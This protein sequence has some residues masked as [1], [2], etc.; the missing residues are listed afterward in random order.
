VCFAPYYLHYASIVLLGVA[1]TAVGAVAVFLTAPSLQ[2]MR[3]GLTSLGAEASAATELVAA[4]T[5]KVATREPQ[6]LLDRTQ[7]RA[8]ARVFTG[9]GRPT[10]VLSFG[11][12]PLSAQRPAAFRAVVAHELA[13]IDNGDARKTEAAVAAWWGLVVA[14]LIPYA[15][16]VAAAITSTFSTGTVVLRDA[17]LLGAAPWGDVLR[18]VAITVLAVLIRNS[19]LRA[20]EFAADRHAADQFGADAD[21][22]MLFGAAPGQEADRWTRLLSV[23][24]P[25][26]VRL[27]RLADPFLGMAVSPWETFT[28]GLLAHLPAAAVSIPLSYLSHG[29]FDATRIVPLISAGTAAVLGLGLWALVW[30]AARAGA[31]TLP[32]RLVVGA[33][34]GL[35]ATVSWILSPGSGGGEPLIQLVTS[36][37][38][39]VAAAIQVTGWTAV[40]LL[41]GALAH[42]WTARTQVMSAR[43]RYQVLAAGGVAAA[44]AA[45]AL[46]LLVDPFA[47][48]ARALWD[49]PF[50]LGEFAAAGTVI[51]VLNGYFWGFVVL[52]MLAV[53]VGRLRLR[54]A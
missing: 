48:I 16:V 3:R 51:A 45:V 9:P 36:P 29:R 5:A 32:A 39:I 43:T 37:L 19:I 35:G 31:C 47:R 10:L 21:L 42:S 34:L 1:C 24:P 20:R 11:M 15:V 12:L 7:A 54:T 18:M 41:I 17:P 25:A 22:R 8:T 28:L 38:L 46:F 13:H 14:A 30:R 26:Q 23:H 44:A 2:V 40:T 4:E 49:M 50:A 33:S 53:L 6:V 52:V 27:D